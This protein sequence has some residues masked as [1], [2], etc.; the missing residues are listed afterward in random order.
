[1]RLIKLK[2]TIM[3]NLFTLFGAAL[4]LNSAN[5][6]LSESFEGGSVPN[7]WTQENVVGTDPWIIETTSAAYGGMGVGTAAAQHGTYYADLWNL[8]VNTNKLITPSMDLSSVTNPTLSFYYVTSGD[9]FGL[10][11]GYILDELKIYY[12]TSAAGSWTLINTSSENHLG[13]NDWTQVTIPLPNPSADYYIAFEG[14]ENSTYSNGVHLDNIEVTGGGSSAVL[15]TTISVDGASGSSTITTPSGTLQMTAAV[16]PANADDNSIT[17][18]VTNGTG[19][20]SISA[21]GL[22]TALSDGTAT[23]TATANDGSGVI[24]TKIIT[25]SNQSTSIFETSVNESFTVYPNPNNG[26]FQLKGAQL[27]AC[28]RLTI[29]NILGESVYQNNNIDSKLNLSHLPKGVYVIQLHDNEKSFSK[30]II[31]E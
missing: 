15:V 8:A 3:K 28:K 4:L 9:L 12:K 11:S 18:S 29:I 2:I 1:M 24:G 22:L 27:E 13:T 10:G 23:V 6:Q 16:L 21:N 19:S 14:H 31:I 25:I 5:A 7:G 30:K 20:A 17:W 26:V